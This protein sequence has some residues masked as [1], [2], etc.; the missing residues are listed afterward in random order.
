[1]AFHPGYSENGYFYVNYTDTNGDTSISRFQVSPENPD[2]ADGGSEKRLLFVAQP[3][4]NH[5]GGAVV[6]GPDGYLYLGLGDGGSGGDP[7]GNGQSTQ[8]LLGKIL[9]IDVDAG[10]PY[11]ILPD[12]P[13][14]SGGGLPEIWSYGLRNPWRIAFDR[15]NGDLFIA[16]VGQNAYEEVNFLPSGSSPGA[17][18][19]WDYREA[20][21]PFEG[22]P[23]DGLTLI[24]PVA[25]YSHG[26]GCS[27][28]GGA[29]YRGASL[30]DW[31]GVYLYGDYCSGMV[32]GL[33]HSPDGSWQQGLLFETGVNITSFGEDQSGELYLADYSGTV[34]R[35]S[36]AQP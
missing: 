4:R 13:F 27:V 7:E 31:T 10:D 12:N 11:A 22:Q 34:Y 6:F 14:A 3:Y 18:F 29:V 32:W 26:S 21:H 19:G 35:L 9:R 15:A 1:L 8:T 23:P 36:P 25:E 28:T 5:N 17:N 2:V 24:D 20:A 33:R 16:D 30:P